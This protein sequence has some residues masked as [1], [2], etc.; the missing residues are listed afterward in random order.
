MVAP[1]TEPMNKDY[2]SAKVQVWFPEGN[3]MISSLEESM[4]EMWCLIFIVISNRFLYLL[5]KERLCLS[6]VRGVKMGVDLPEVIDWY[7]FPGT[8]H[9]FEMVEDLDGARCVTTLSVDWKLG[10]IQL[11]VEGDKGIFPETESTAFMFK[12]AKQR[13]LN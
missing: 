1:I 9:S 13:V 5:K 4:Q 3:G 10:A 12:E 8:H 11:S 6:M 2:Q 7:V